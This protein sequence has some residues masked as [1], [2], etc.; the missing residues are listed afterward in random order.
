MSYKIVSFKSIGC[1]GIE[2]PTCIEF[3]P[4]TPSPYPLYVEQ[5]EV[6]SREYSSFF[7]EY[8]R[9]I[10][11]DSETINGPQL[12]SMILKFIPVTI[13]LDSFF[14]KPCDIDDFIQF[15]CN[16][17]LD[18]FNKFKNELQSFLLSI[19][20]INRLYFPVQL[21]EANKL[22]PSLEDLLDLKYGIFTDLL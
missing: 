10:E 17:H 11:Q 2:S 8:N 12:Q 13:V 14:D 20:S 21:L 5:M 15:C 3:G 18:K 6:F 19:K 22:C 16:N 1:R 7:N 4:R 9:F